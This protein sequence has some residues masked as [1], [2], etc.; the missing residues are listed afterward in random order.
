[1]IAIS[2]VPH[3]TTLAEAQGRMTLPWVNWC[4]D[5]RNALNVGTLVLNT[6]PALTAQSASIG[7]T[8]VPLPTLTE[9]LYRVSWYFRVTTVDAV[10]SSLRLTIG[11]TDG[12]VACTQATAAYTGN[13]VTA[14]Q[15]GVFLVRA[16]A[17]S[18]I[19][20]ATT[21]ASNTPG[22]MIYALSVAIEQVPL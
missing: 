17:G 20:Y 21:Y 18:S 1:M 8:A 15:S 11:H 7:A 12:A 2:P 13:V 19:T 14:P 10:S 6:A 3:Q 9:G 4:N 16:D 5:V 22:Q